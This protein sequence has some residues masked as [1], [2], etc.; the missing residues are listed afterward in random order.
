MPRNGERL[1]T[2]GAA[3][4]DCPCTEDGGW[5]GSAIAQDEAT[6]RQQSAALD[7]QRALADAVETRVVDAQTA[8]SKQ[9][10]AR[11][12]DIEEHNDQGAKR[13]GG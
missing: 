7:A 8:P 10:Q 3:G 1:V 13:R 12:P 11:L 4:A 9:L 2:L 6:L 5:A